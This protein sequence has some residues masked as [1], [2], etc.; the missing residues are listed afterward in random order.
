MNA[1]LEGDV[2]T[3][4]VVGIGDRPELRLARKR[5][6]VGDIELAP[7]RKLDDA[8]R[9]PRRERGRRRSRRSTRR[10]T[11]SSRGAARRSPSA[12]RS[13]STRPDD[14]EQFVRAARARG[15]PA[16]AGHELTGRLRAR[17]ADADAPRSTRP[18]CPIVERTAAIVEEALAR[19]RAR[20]AA[21]RAA[22]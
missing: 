12:A 22:R 17:D 4:G 15:L 13:P 10:S 2:G 8:A 3:V 11:S 7:G 5:T 18:S 1:L 20:R 16:C 19:G 14:E 6:R 9:V 21:A